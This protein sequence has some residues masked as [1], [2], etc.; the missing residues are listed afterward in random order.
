MKYRKL[1]LVLVLIAVVLA[2]ASYHA[3]AVT[4]KKIV[5]LTIYNLSAGG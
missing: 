2:F 4:E 1:V 3:V 5:K